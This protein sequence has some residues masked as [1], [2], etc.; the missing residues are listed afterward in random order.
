MAN[1]HL[2][3]LFLYQIVKSQIIQGMWLS[4]V[5]IWSQVHII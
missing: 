2:M 3:Y 5:V 4:V 1:I